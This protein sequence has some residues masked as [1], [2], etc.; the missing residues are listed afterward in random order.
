MSEVLEKKRAELEELRQEVRDMERRET[1]EKLYPE[2]K[3]LEGTFWKQRNS[4]D[5]SNKWLVFM[6]VVSV[7]P[8]G[9]LWMHTFETCSGGEV[10]ILPRKKFWWT[11]AYQSIINS[12]IPSTEMEYSEAWDAL[13]DHI[14]PVKP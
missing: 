1:A 2:K 14:A 7:E 10:R 3:L 12:W 4:Y 13:M 5:A 9:V 8:D 6:K 11:E